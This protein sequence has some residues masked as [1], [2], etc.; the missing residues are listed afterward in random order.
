MKSDAPVARAT[1]A[2]F[3]QVNR[4]DSGNPLNPAN[5]YNPNVPFAPLGGGSGIE[6]IR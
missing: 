5:K 2:P 3:N 1:L 4:Y 6:K